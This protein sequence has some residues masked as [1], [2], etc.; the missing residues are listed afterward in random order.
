MIIHRYFFSHLIMFLPVRIREHGRVRRERVF[1]PRFRFPLTREETRPDL[2]P[3]TY[4]LAVFR[5]YTTLN[6]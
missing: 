2:V 6:E 4:L 1:S 3:T 5:N